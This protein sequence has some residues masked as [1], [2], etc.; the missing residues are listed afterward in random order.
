MKQ[1]TNNSQISESPKE[2]HINPILRDSNFSS[3]K[4]DPEN[5]GA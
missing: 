2:G 3:Q 5:M 4:S 1:N